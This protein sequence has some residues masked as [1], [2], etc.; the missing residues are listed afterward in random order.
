MLIRTLRKKSPAKID[1]LGRK[2]GRL[3]RKADKKRARTAAANLSFAFP[4]MGEQEK[5]EIIEKVYDHFGMVGLDF[6]AGAD[7]TK[8]D[9]EAITEVEGIEHLEEARAQGKGLL[10]ITGHFGNWERIAAWFAVQGHPMT[11]VARD[12]DQDDVN[13]IVN[14]IR[15][16]PGT[17]V[18]AR[19]DAARPI[20]ERLKENRPIGILPDQNAKDAFVPFFGKP[21]GTVLGPGVMAERLGAAILPTVCLYH[22]EG[23]CTLKFYPLLEWE[24]I[25]DIKGAGT[26]VAINQWL[27]QVILENPEQWLWIHDRWR[28][29]R[30]EGL[31]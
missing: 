16:A 9:I 31:L 29:A 24:P 11:V 27:E 28:L 23:R 6:F 13:D 25:E 21:A 18:V 20:V 4:D 3:L 26:M 22:G 17:E 1:R 19:G 8:E 7:R 10:M 12:A 14:Q 2:L 15:R 5:Q 30:R